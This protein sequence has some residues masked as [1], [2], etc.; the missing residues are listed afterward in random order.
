MRTRLQTGLLLV[1]ML[2]AVLLSIFMWAVG[3]IPFDTYTSALHIASIYI[4]IAV[5]LLYQR[6]RRGEL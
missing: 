3:K 6:R 4:G 1:S 5:V 2:C